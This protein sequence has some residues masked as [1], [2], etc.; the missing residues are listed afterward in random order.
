M[1]IQEN[2]LKI[3]GEV[4][5]FIKKYPFAI[6]MLC[7]MGIMVGC[8]IGIGYFV[9]MRH[10]LRHMNREEGIAFIPEE[11]PTLPCD[12][13]PHIPETTSIPSVVQDTKLSIKLHGNPNEN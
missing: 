3:K 11:K 12:L 5:L 6:I 4:T 13:Y 7:Y 9:G 1:S 8:L 10:T 2:V